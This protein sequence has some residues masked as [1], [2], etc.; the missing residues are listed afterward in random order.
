MWIIA[1]LYERYIATISRAFIRLASN[2]AEANRRALNNMHAERRAGASSVPSVAGHD[3]GI[4]NRAKLVQA[5]DAAD[6]AEFSSADPAPIIEKFAPVAEPVPAVEAAP[7]V[8][9]AVA[10]VTPEVP[11]PANRPHL[12]PNRSFPMGVRGE[13][14]LGWAEALLDATRADVAGLVEKL[15]KDKR[16]RVAELRII[17]AEVLGE[18][19]QNRKK[20]EHL[21]AIRTHLAPEF[22]KTASAP[23]MAAHA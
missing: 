19:P 15:R 4:A 22:G 12:D 11:A 13:V 18:E 10:Q 8:G 16:V 9:E 1:N 21:A 6:A 2:E 20:G 17:A 5:V 7:I 23:E 3:A 14:V